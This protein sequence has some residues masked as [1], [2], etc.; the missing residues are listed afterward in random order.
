MSYIQKTIKRV[1]AQEKGELII[2]FNLRKAME[3]IVFLGCEGLNECK[4]YADFFFAIN[5]TLW[6][7]LEEQKEKKVTGLDFVV[8][9]MFLDPIVKGYCGATETTEDAGSPWSQWEKLTTDNFGNLDLFHEQIL[10]TLRGPKRRSKFDPIQKLVFNSKLH[11]SYSIYL[12][13]SSAEVLN[14]RIK[15][16][17]QNQQLI[18]LLIITTFVCEMYIKKII[19]YVQGISILFRLLFVLGRNDFA[20]EIST[21]E[22][23]KCEPYISAEKG[24]RELDINNLFEV[25]KYLFDIEENGLDLLTIERDIFRITQLFYRSKESS[26]PCSILIK[27][28]YINSGHKAKS[29]SAL[30]VDIENFYYLLSRLD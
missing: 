15:A 23:A 30:G 1:I 8:S 25:F 17:K 10:A 9:K 6:K 26:V 24:Y 28:L 19:D 21:T 22:A 12:F 3:S 20:D 7:A 18:I 29:E 2:F 5:Y 11:N 16:A 13:T 27:R 4:I 14:D